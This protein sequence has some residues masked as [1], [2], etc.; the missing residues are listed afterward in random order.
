MGLL[1][2]AIYS[3]NNKVRATTKAAIKYAII[4]ALIETGILYLI[5]P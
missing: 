5:F 3:T 4:I 2:E 1:K